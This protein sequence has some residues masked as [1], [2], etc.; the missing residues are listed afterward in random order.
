M[1]NAY[2]I[3]KGEYSKNENNK[4]KKNGKHLENIL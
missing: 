2:G 4:R 1:S 3:S